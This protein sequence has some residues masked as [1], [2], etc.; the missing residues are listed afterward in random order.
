MQ[1][2]EKN[3]SR[4]ITFS[5]VHVNINRKDRCNGTGLPG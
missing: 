2:M 1:R 4:A 5:V 3:V